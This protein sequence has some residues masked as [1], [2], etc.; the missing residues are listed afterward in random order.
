ML[1]RAS[2]FLAALL[3]A[4]AGLVSNSARAQDGFELLQ[5]A[6]HRHDPRYDNDRIYDDPQY[7]YRYRWVRVRV[8]PRVNMHFGDTNFS[9]RIGKKKDCRRVWRRVRVDDYDY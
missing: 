5:P 8:C 9:I 2:L 1:L 4:G 3:F 6:N 7:V